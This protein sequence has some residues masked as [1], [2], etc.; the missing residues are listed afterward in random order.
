MLRCFATFCWEAPRAC[1][2]SVTVASAF[3]QAVQQLDRYRLGQHAEALSDQLDEL[4]GERV[5]NRCLDDIGAKGSTNP[6]LCS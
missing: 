2:S 5:G 1:C 3:A 4:V 6:R